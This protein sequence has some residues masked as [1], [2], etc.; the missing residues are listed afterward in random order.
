MP[1]QAGYNRADVLGVTS[2]GSTSVYMPSTAVSESC[3]SF[4]SAN[5]S[6]VIITSISAS[7]SRASAALGGPRSTLGERRSATD[8]FLELVF[9]FFFCFAMLRFLCAY[10]V[11]YFHYSALHLVCKDLSK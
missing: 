6:A 5:F 9:D 3:W 10:D 2:G 4:W 8:F 1:F 11:R 7:S